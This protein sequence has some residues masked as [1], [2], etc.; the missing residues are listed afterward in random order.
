[1]P[2]VAGQAR[3]SSWFLLSSPGSDL[4]WERYCSEHVLSAGCLSHQQRGQRF[5]AQGHTHMTEGADVERGSGQKGI[6]HARAFEPLTFSPL[7][8]P[9]SP[10]GSK[11]QRPG[12]WDTFWGCGGGCPGIGIWADR[13]EHVMG[14]SVSTSAATG[15]NIS[16]PRAELGGAWMTSS[17]QGLRGRGRHPSGPGPDATVVTPL[18]INPADLSGLGLVPSCP[19]LLGAL[20]PRRPSTL[21]AVAF[22]GCQRPR[23]LCQS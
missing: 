22:Q 15:T 9:G 19:H 18:C 13:K 16:V 17:V 20:V 5:S 21:T 10:L 12:I 7:A 4:T 2:W 1:M 14:S 3:L 23:C 6:P 8:K 11:S